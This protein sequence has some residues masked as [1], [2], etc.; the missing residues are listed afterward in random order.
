MKI[1][2]SNRDV[3]LGGAVVLFVATILGLVAGVFRDE[4]ATAKNLLRL[5]QLAA[6][7]GGSASNGR[8]SHRAHVTLT[9]PGARRRLSDVDVPRIVDV[10]RAA[11]D[12]KIWDGIHLDLYGQNITDEGLQSLA[13][14]DVELGTLFLTSDRLTEAAVMRVRVEHPDWDVRW[15]PRVAEETIHSKGRPP[16][17]P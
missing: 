12:Q 3:V 11:R 14:A 7:L 17:M 15:R 9:F 8:R 5:T 6:P 16:T 2:A 4:A 1:L 10:L 13:N